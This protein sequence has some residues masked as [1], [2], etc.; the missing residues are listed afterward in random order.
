V[1][2]SLG[3]EREKVGTIGENKSVGTRENIATHH[4]HNSK[5]LICQKNDENRG[6]QLESQ[7]KALEKCKK[8]SWNFKRG[9]G[10][11]GG[12]HGGGDNCGLRKCIHIE[13]REGGS[14]RQS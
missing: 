3:G 7:G 13:D 1:T 4:Q 8:Q 14:R 6:A 10:G 2:P 9:G 12:K 11:I 5:R